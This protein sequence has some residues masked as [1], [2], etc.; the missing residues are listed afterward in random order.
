MKSEPVGI[1][2]AITV[3]IGAILTALAAFGLDV[4]EEQRN[5]IVGVAVAAV[6]VIGFMAAAIRHY[7]YSPR[8]VAEKFIRVEDAQDPP[9]EVPVAEPRTTFETPTMPG[10]GR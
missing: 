3:F 10:G 7:V 4:T 6:P 1:I 9:A 2:A 5:A 8:T